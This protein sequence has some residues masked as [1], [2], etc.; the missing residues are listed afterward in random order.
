MYEILDFVEKNQISVFRLFSMNLLCMFMNFYVCFMF[1]SCIFIIFYAILKIVEAPEG[2]E[3]GP[4]PQ[5][6][7]W[8]K[9]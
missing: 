4:N 2:P 1:F 8:H 5:F 3:G 9:K 6:V 7:K